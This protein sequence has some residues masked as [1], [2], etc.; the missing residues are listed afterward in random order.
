MQRNLNLYVLGELNGGNLIAP[1][2][3][4]KINL[5]QWLEPRRML[6]DRI[7]ILDGKIINLGINF[8][9]LA[10]LD[11]NRVALPDR[12]ELGGIEIDVLK[13]SF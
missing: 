10:D 5:R 3:E 13:V 7:D 12:N 9:V 4:L 11:V 6:S 8:E 1:N 2:S